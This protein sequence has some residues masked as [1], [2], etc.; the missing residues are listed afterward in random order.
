[1]S[2]YLVSLIR[3]GVPILVGTIF[4]YIT[5]LGWFDVSAEDQA[6]VTSLVVGAAIAVYY[7]GVRKLEQK[8]PIFGVLLGSTQQPEY[9][10]PPAKVEAEG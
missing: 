10:Q 4:G 7:A 6:K 1:M 2:N 3:T 8:W 9:V 5:S